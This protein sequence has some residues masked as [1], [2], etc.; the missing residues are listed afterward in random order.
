MTETDPATEEVPVAVML[1]DVV[2]EVV[3]ALG[4][5]E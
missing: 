1:I 4:L 2:L 5:T 3:L